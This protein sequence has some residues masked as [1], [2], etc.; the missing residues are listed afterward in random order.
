VVRDLRVH[1]RHTR[2]VDH[3]DLRAVGPNRAQQLLGELARALGVDHADDRQDQQALAHLQ[4]RRRQLA[5]GFLLL[6]DD[7]LALLHE[8]HRHRRRDPVGRRLVGI[9]HPVQESE[10]GLVLLEQ[11][12]GQH[13]AQQEHDPDDLGG[14]DAP[15][16]DPFRQA[17]GVGLECL[18]ATGLQ[19]FDVV[20]EHRGGFGEDL[21][22]GHRGEQPGF[23]DPSYPFFPQLRPVA[24]EVGDELAQY[25]RAGLHRRE[26]FRTWG[27]RVSS[28]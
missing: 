15:R 3:H 9:E 6:A 12:A 18:H 14:V 21:F 7:A 27:H 19:H 20:V 25:V 13:V 4:H 1:R 8:P 2:D 24:S 23:G 10:V 16:D 26:L 17:A 22:L 11:R 28:R 5:D